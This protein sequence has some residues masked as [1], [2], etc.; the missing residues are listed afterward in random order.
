MDAPEQG[1]F[2][3]R[4][5]NLIFQ[6][7]TGAFFVSYRVAVH[8]PHRLQVCRILGRV[9]DHPETLRRI[10]PAINK[11]DRFGLAR[12]LDASVSHHNQQSACLG[13]NQ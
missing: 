3:G 11:G 13:Y 1:L 7:Q 12:P 8:Q 9:P 4:D 2:V 5:G 10:C 6:F